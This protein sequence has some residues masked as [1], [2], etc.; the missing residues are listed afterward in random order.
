MTRHDPRL[1]LQHMLDHAREALQMVE[2]RTRTDLDKN[3]PLELALVRLLEVVGEAA[4]RVP[5]DLQERY[6]G[7]PWRAVIGLRNRL[8]HGYDSVD[9][10]I[11]WQIVWQIVRED[12]A[13]LIRALEEGPARL[14]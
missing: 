1:A 12:L 3:R 5:P 4:T 11:V 7:V 8:I 9:L 13:P 6:S 10:D 2:A 14:E